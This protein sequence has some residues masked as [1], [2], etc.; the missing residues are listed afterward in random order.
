MSETVVRH[1][2]RLRWQ[3]RRGMRELDDL[4]MAWMEARFEHAP[5]AQKAA[6]EMLLELPDPELASYLLRGEP[7]GSA[8]AN[9]VIKQIRDRTCT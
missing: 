4:L 8:D 2:A 1:T 5:E 7:A 6:F 9:D 3:C